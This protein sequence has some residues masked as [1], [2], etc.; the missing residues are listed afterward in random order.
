M[1]FGVLKND[2]L[3]NDVQ[4]FSCLEEPLIL[5]DV[6]VLNLGQYAKRT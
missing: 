5:D 2:A 6:W 4:E 1:V 3:K